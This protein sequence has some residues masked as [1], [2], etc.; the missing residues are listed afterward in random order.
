MNAVSSPRRVLLVDDDPVTLEI[1]KAALEDAGFVVTT[2]E[3]AF[4]TSN[5]IAEERP[6]VVLADVTMPGLTGDGLVRV[7]AA[8][9]Q[10]AGTL[11]ILYSARRAADL[12]KLAREVGAAGAIV[13]TGDLDAFVAEF[14]RILERRQPARGA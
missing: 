10:L 1:V 12:E 13:K 7:G 4:G 3:R 14:K 6:D 8:N 5:V 2:R 9:P 11:F